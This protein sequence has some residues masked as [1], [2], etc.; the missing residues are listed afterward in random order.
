MT[1]NFCGRAGESGIR[2]GF[3]SLRAGQ[4]EH[5]HGVGQID[6]FDF[7]AQHEHLQALLRGFLQIGRQTE[8]I[9]FSLA[10][11]DEAGLHATFGG[12]PAS[13]LCLMVGQMIDIA[14]E[15]AVQES[16]GIVT[17][18]LDQG[19]VSERNDNGTLRGRQQFAGRIAEVEKFSRIAVEDTF[20]RFQKAAPVGV[21]EG[22]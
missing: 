19:K 20:G 11:C 21:H 12:T 15:L 17:C 4:A 5:D 3:F 14:G 13:M 7:G 10:P 22:S 9:T 16:L 18:C 2:E 6:E 1:V 8:E